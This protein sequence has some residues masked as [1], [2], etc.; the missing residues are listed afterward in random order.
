M[1]GVAQ[2]HDGLP[3]CLGDDEWI[4]PLPG[5]PEDAV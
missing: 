5:R 1:F 4:V 2:H 3:E